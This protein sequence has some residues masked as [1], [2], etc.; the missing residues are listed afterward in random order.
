MRGGSWRREAGWVLARVAERLSGTTP[1]VL[2]DD[3]DV[4]LG[5]PLAQS[6]ASSVSARSTG[7]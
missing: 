5:D 4:V 2:G 3:A 1:G 6:F 7:R